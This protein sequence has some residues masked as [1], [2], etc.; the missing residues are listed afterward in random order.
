V[1]NQ[2]LGDL[3]RSLVT[4]HHSKWDQILSQAEFAYNDSVK[5]S[6]GNSPFHIVYGLNPRG[7]SELRDLEQSEFRSVGAEDFT[8][9]MQNLHNNIKE[10]L[11]NSSRE[12]KG[13]VDQHRRE[14]QF[15]V[16]YQVLAH[17]RKEMFPSGTYNKLKL[18]KIGPCKIL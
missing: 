11:Q 13:R 5:K 1:V 6:T 16:G 2:I 14:L 9:E 3:L 17:L 8:A 10:K 12:Y 4:K 18:K 15:E 7:V